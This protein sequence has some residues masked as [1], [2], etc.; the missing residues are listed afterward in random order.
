MQL[1]T[2]KSKHGLVGTFTNIIKEEGYVQRQLR[3]L[4]SAYH[5]LTPFLI[6]RWSFISRYVSVLRAEWAF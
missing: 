6:K 1:E 5:D 3:A 4:I 2:G